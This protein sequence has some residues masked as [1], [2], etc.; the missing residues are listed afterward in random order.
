MA[1]WVHVKLPDGSEVPASAGAL[2]RRLAPGSPL[3]VALESFSEDSDMGQSA[4]QRPGG[5]VVLDIV[6]ESPPAL[7][8]GP[9]GMEA[10]R[11]LV[12]HLG[13]PEGDRLVFTCLERELSVALA[14]HMY[15]LAHWLL[16]LPVT[17][18]LAAWLA[19]VWLRCPK[20]LL[21]GLGEADAVVARAAVRAGL[22][23]SACIPEGALC[24][25]AEAEIARAEV[26]MDALVAQVAAEKATIARLRPLAS[27][28]VQ[29]GVDPVWRC[30]AVVEADMFPIFLKFQGRS[31]VVTGCT[32]QTIAQELKAWA[33]SRLGVP[34]LPQRLVFEGRPLPDARCLGLAGVRRDSTVHL[35]V[36][37][38]M[39]RG[40]APRRV[41]V[42]VPEGVQGETVWVSDTDTSEDVLQRIRA[43]DDR[44]TSGGTLC[45]GGRGLHP[46]VPLANYHLPEAAALHALLRKRPRVR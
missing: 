29:E 43:I 41:I 18:R 35:T 20:T 6:G 19:S 39:C 38:E 10:L 30:P 32:A 11:T 42:F 13:H 27:V 2:A 22:F 5:D 14:V 17:T 24:K 36:A 37:P 34:E 46:F 15:P 16:A 3:L 26:N 40:K 33:A 7:W 25:A 44:D 12:K 28:L 9:L 1:S 31:H 8:R 45:Y 23:R 4:P 21:A